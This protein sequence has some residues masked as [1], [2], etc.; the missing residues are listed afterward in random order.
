MRC[1][2]L[3]G[4]GGG[5]A[6][7]FM[8]SDG[9]ALLNCLSAICVILNIVALAWGEWLILFEKSSSGDAPQ[10]T[11]TIG[12]TGA[13]CK[14]AEST[15]CRP[16]ALFQV[17]VLL[18]SLLPCL[19][20]CVLMPLSC[21][22]VISVHRRSRNQSTTGTRPIGI[23]A[24]SGTGR[25]RPAG[26]ESASRTWWKKRGSSFPAGMQRC[27]PPPLHVLPRL[28]IIHAHVP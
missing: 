3:V 2:L 25:G 11:I 23:F 6:P 13:W 28:N 18:M 15:G 10:A 24:T 5:T 26:P 14:S 22:H 4:R 8:A 27:F 16:H 21:V 17:R 9:P 19:C 1:L 12:L 7:A 20:S